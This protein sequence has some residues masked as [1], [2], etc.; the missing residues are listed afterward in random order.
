MRIGKNRDGP[1]FAQKCLQYPSLICVANL[2]NRSFCK[3][4]IEATTP[5]K[6]GTAFEMLSFEILLRE[7]AFSS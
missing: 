7:K 5:T 2:S 6:F 4:L 3:A 1:R